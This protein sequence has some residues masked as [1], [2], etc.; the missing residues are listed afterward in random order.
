LAAAAAAIYGGNGLWA[1]DT[2]KPNTAISS[3][4]R[5]GQQ[6]G[7]KKGRNDMYII[8]GFHLTYIIPAKVIC[9]KFR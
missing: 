5:N 2:G 1:D 6:R 9:P 8:T 4:G 3:Y 7:D